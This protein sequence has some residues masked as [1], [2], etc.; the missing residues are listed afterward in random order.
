MRQLAWIADRLPGPR[1]RRCVRGEQTRWRVSLG[2]F[3][4][5]VIAPQLKATGPQTE[6]GRAT[7]PPAPWTRDALLALSEQRFVVADDAERQRL[8]IGLVSCLDDPDPALRDEVGYSAL[9]AWLRGKSLAPPTVVA[10]SDVMLARLE[11]PDDPAGFGRPFAAL[12]L[13]EIARADRLDL[14]LPER[15]VQA[16]VGAA[17]SFLT[18]IRDYRGLDPREGWRHGV[19]HGADLVL[20][21]GL[22]P[23]IGGNE[24]RRLLAAVATQ[25]VPGGEVFYTDGE[26]ERLARAV[27]FLA[28]REE[29]DQL[30]WYGWFEAIGAPSP[31]PSWSNATQSR[32][33]L[34]RRHNTIAFLSAVAFAARASASAEN[35]PLAALAARELRRIM[36]GS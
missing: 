4:V 25:V 21:L 15:T 34:A 31:L 14:V 7:C 17:E 27:F 35:T 23:R 29:L 5:V 12:V 13:S 24:L 3:A 32:P 30:F 33:G 26:S 36:S 20:Q 6:P 2:L 10:L 9:A 18:G 19:A 28:R 1:S 16:M 11:K 8:A 22:N